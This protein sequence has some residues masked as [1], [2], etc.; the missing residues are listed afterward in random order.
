MSVEQRL[1][2]DKIASQEGDESAREIEA[3]VVKTIEAIIAGRPIAGSDLVTIASYDTSL[4]E[5]ILNF[6]DGSLDSP[7]DSIAEFA[8]QF[9]LTTEPDRER[10]FAKIDNVDSLMNNHISVK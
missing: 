2:F 4:A 3:L 9:L 6:L 1:A 10:F 8:E 5:S 7:L